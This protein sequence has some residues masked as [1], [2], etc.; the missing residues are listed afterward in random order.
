M[1]SADVIG[2]ADLRKLC[3]WRGSTR[4]VRR[5]DPPRA[6]SEVFVYRLAVD[7]ETGLSM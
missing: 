5:E 6:L 1:L 4:D 2:D 7:L 3:K